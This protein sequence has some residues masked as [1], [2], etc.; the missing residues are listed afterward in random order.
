MYGTFLAR[1]QEE[2]LTGKV[3]EQG[4]NGLEV[5]NFEARHGTPESKGWGRVCTDNNECR[6]VLVLRWHGI[7]AE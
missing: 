5:V 4:E 1:Q 2:Y 3:N 7:N 6:M